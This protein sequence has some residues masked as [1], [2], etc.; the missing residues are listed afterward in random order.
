ML[1]LLANLFG[2][3]AIST[4]ANKLAD[5]Y[6]AK[7][8]ALTDSARIEADAQIKTLEAQRDVLV[9]EAASGGPASWIRPLLALPFVLY[10]WK[11]VPVD[12]IACPII[13]GNECATD[14]LSPQLTE[15]MMVVIGG[16]FIG[17]SAEKVA[18]IIKR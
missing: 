17:R 18:R 4:I 8:D 13:F 5:A 11:L 15:I 2:G 10:I 16:Y 12:K 6:K 7:Q 14:P 9:A 1:G 3:G